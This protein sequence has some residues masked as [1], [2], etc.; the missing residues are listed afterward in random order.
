LLE[1]CPGSSKNFFRGY[2]P[3][4][5]RVEFRHPAFGFLTPELAPLLFCNRIE[6]VKQKFREPATS[7]RLKPEGLLFELFGGS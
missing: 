6:T 2:G 7:L 3:G 4:R 5:V 1:Q